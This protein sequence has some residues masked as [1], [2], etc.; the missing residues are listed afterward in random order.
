MTLKMLKR[1]SYTAKIRLRKWI[2][3]FWSMRTKVFGA[4]LAFV[5]FIRVFLFL[6]FVTLPPNEPS[7]LCS[8]GKGKFS[9]KKLYILLTLLFLFQEGWAIKC[10][11]WLQCTVLQES[12]GYILWW[13]RSSLNS[14]NFILI[15]RKW[16][17]QYLRGTCRSSMFKSLGSNFLEYGGKYPGLQ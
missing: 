14:C 12:M 17:W 9:C 10:L 3:I 16:N 6:W 2:F 8:F 15:S 4:F 7:F 5:I 11:P 13:P 1:I